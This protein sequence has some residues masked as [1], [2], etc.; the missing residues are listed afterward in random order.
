MT[1]GRNGPPPADG[2]RDHRLDP[3]RSA[4]VLIGVG[5][6][7]D[8][9][10]LKSVSH[11]LDALERAL[12]DEAVWGVPEDHRWVV[13]NP[14]TQ[15]QMIKPIQEAAEKAE[16]TL[17]VYYAG[18]GLLDS[19]DDAL[20][21]TLTVSQPGEPTLALSYEELRRTLGDVRSSVRRR[22]VIL[23]CC[24]SGQVLDRM[25]A[26]EAVSGRITR[27]DGSYIMTSTAGNR[28]AMAPRGSKY[29][30]FTGEF[31]KALTES[32]ARF[33]REKWLTLDQIYQVV[34]ESLLAKGLPEPQQQSRNGVGDL[35]FVR[36]PLRQ[37][38]GLAEPPPYWTGRKRLL[39]SAVLLVVA[40]TS[41][42]GGVWWPP[43]QEPPTS[44]PCGTE[45]V[46]LL[47]TSDDLDE[48][49]LHGEQIEGLSALA[50]D[51]T[52][53][54]ALAL[55]DDDPG[56]IYRL[57]LGPAAGLEPRARR[58]QGL[59]REDGTRYSHG[60][61]GEGLV[62]EKG[63]KTVLVS[64]EGSPAIRRFDLKTGRELGRVPLPEL[65]RLPP[66]GQAQRSRN[67]ESLTATDDGRHLFVGLEAPLAG[68]DDKHGRAGLRIQR[69]EGTPGGSYRPDHQYAYETEEGMY[70]SELVALDGEHLLALE[71]GGLVG[72][73]NSIHVYRV[74]LS[75]AD[76][77]AGGGVGEGSADAYTEK[78]LLFDLAACPP[79]RVKSKR[80]QPNDI[81]ENVEGMAVGPP[82]KGEEHRGRRLL[83]LVSD[84]NGQHDR[85]TRLYALSVRLP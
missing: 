46:S 73:G 52:S 49:P 3:A 20:H 21:L 8:L 81:V 44:G 55:P 18:H 56:R 53:G 69:Y 30:A 37:R 84:D 75:D 85:R 74:D 54:D 31:L 60:F 6:Y 29:T 68:D 65:F 23:D 50:L 48:A 35:P 24:Y 45:D 34:R 5:D 40:A 14:R 76:D 61:D 28:R 39:A 41:A 83:Y 17:L 80:P 4:C 79:G 19:G 25:S 62:L 13:R 64:T 82:P 67:V 71:R 9:P 2:A 57:S 58:V 15:W 26:R 38:S 12:A 42:A 63:G 47:S 66:A 36:N 16:D 33:E 27:I 43:G 78:E 11:N 32:D 51:G 7:T 77:V 59:Y 22:V 70:L 1:G 10:P 72:L